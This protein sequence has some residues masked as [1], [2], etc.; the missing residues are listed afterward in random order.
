M[1]AAGLVC[2]LGGVICL[3]GHWRQR[4]LWI[5]QPR[6][7]LQAVLAAGLLLANV[8]MAVAYMAVVLR[9]VSR[10]TL[11]VANQS[12]A[13]ID[14]LTVSAPGIGRVELGPVASG[15]EIMRHFHFS[16]DGRLVFSGRQ[17]GRSFEGELERSVVEGFG[18][19]KSIRVATDGTWH[20]E[21]KGPPV[22]VVEQEPSNQWLEPVADSDPIQ[23]AT[24]PS[25]LRRLV[26]LDQKLAPGIHAFARAGGQLK[27]G[28]VM[29]DGP[30]VGE[31]LFAIEAGRGSQVHL[32][33]HRD[34]CRVE[35]GRVLER[36]IFSLSG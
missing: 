21:P 9:I 14:S 31:S 30:Q 29:T 12:H 18:G 7:R 19:R 13:P 6:A 28:G 26:L 16:S 23:R 20:I 34:V 33:E 1:I 24:T 2:F 3:L 4:A 32:G 8:P 17:Q 10:Y 15:Q 27:N 36:F 25:G 35:H 11:Q 5:R 22:R